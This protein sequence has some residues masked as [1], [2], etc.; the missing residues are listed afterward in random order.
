M[1]IARKTEQIDIQVITDNWQRQKIDRII[2]FCFACIEHLSFA[3]WNVSTMAND[4]PVKVDV[5]SF[6]FKSCSAE[7]GFVQQLFFIRFRS[8]SNTLIRLN[9]PMNH[10]PMHVDNSYYFRKNSWDNYRTV[11][12]FPFNTPKKSMVEAIA[13][14]SHWLVSMIV[15]TN[16]LRLTVGKSVFYFVF[17]LVSS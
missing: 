6:Q 15:Q 17:E 3:R 8:H 14:P 1:K 11:F 7:T 10:F 9:F 16:L 13:S 5:S 2:F 4:K 12:C